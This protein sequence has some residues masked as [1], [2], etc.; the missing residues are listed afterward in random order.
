MLLSH[1]WL[2]PLSKPATISEEDELEGDLEGLELEDEHCGKPN[3]YDK[4]VA[5]WVIAALEKKRSG[6]MGEAAKPALH[7]APLDSVSP[8]ASPAAAVDG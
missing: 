1:G 8:A 3:S 5:E 6:K 4:E 7:A 2:A